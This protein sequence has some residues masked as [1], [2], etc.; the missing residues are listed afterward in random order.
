MNTSARFLDSL[1][2]GKPEQR[3]SEP[4]P[5]RGPRP[6][7]KSARPSSP[8]P[9][10]TRFRDRAPQTDDERHGPNG[11][12]PVSDDG[13]CVI[14]GHQLPGFAIPETG[15]RPRSPIGDHTSAARKTRKFR[16]AQ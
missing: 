10:N 15:A 8:M 1:V 6:S 4:N 12:E 16:G 2:E 11:H 5:D 14:C 9:E 13:T 3:G 7:A